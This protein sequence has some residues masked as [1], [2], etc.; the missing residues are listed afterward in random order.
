MEFYFIYP[1]YINKSFIFRKS[2]SKQSEC[3]H[4]LIDCC[5]ENFYRWNI[6]P[7]PGR[8][9]PGDIASHAFC[10]S[11]KIVARKIRFSLNFEK[12]SMFEMGLLFLWKNIRLLK[13][14]AFSYL[15]IYFSILSNVLYETVCSWCVLKIVYFIEYLILK[16]SSFNR[17]LAP[18]TQFV[19]QIVLSFFSSSLWHHRWNSFSVTKIKIYYILG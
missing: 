3:N 4:C 1:Y 12:S 14:L 15:A 16:I 11:R 19:C 5:R 10:W 2:S 6:F 17:L 9:F 8:V 7:K 18:L 13:T